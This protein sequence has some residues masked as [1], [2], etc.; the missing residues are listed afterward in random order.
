MDAVAVTIIGVVGTALFGM[1]FM[2]F[3]N[4]RDDMTAGFAAVNA[5]L[6]KTPGSTVKTPG[7]TA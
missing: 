7:S 2:Q 3:K 1:F 6:V 5:R 4:L